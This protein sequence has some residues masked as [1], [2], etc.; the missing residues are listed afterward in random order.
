MTLGWGIIHIAPEDFDQNKKI[1]P[2]SEQ[3]STLTNTV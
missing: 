3:N 1:S 2:L